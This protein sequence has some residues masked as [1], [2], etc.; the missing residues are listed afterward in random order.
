MG[1]FRTS[2]ARAHSRGTVL[3]ARCIR[4][5]TLS[6][7]VAAATFPTSSKVRRQMMRLTEP[8]ASPA[9]F[10]AVFALGNSVS[11]ESFFTGGTTISETMLRVTVF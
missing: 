9:S 7:V 1:S 5:R 11:P 3:V 8:A 2:I 10:C 4:P 6:L